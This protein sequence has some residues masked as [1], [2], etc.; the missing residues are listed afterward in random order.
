MSA[1]SNWRD[2][3]VYHFT[4]I[5]GLAKILGDGELRCDNDVQ[6]AGG[7]IE[8]G[9]QGLKATRRRTP[10]PCGPGGVVADYVPFY[11]ASKSPM[12][13]RVATGR[14][15]YK[16]GEGPLVFFATTMGTVIDMS[17]PFVFTDGHPTAAYSEFFDDVE[18]VSAID[19]GLMGQRDWYATDADPDRQTRRQAEL[20]VHRSLPLEAVVTLAARSDSIAERAKEIVTSM[21]YNLTVATRPDWYYN[22]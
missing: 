20:L 18:N 3:F 11:Y 9:D 19:W 10:V 21:G 15:D 17:L 7:C 8:V 5:D 14:V 4:H 12:L 1:P 13:L 16:G 6:A 2:R 22:R